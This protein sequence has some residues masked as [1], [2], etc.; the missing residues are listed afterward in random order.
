MIKF[1]LSCLS[2]RKIIPVLFSLAILLFLLPSIVQSSS[3]SFASA[4]SPGLTVLCYNLP[5]G[6]GV[7]GIYPATGGAFVEDFDRGNLVF[8]SGG[9]SKTIATA[10]PGGLYA[11][12]YYGMGAI[13][14]KAFGLVLALVTHN[15]AYSGISGLWLCYHANTSG[16]G[17]ESAFIPLP[18]SFCKSEK[19]HFCGPNGA[20]L[21]SSLNLFYVDG[22]NQQLVEC[23]S[24]SDYKSCI[25]LPASS[26]L[27]GSTPAGLFLSG[28]TFYVTDASC[29]GKVWTGTSSK[30]TLIAT[31]GEDI[32][33]IA[34]SANNPSGTLHVYLGVTGYCH[35]KAAYIL[36]LGDN[37][38]LPTP[39][40]FPND[41]PGLDSSL[42]FTG[43]FGAAYRTTDTS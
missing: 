11:F 21:D 34:L 16:C 9:H 43:V 35:N 29:S 13:N 40:G 8:C 18:S 39:F 27:K 17:S 1:R 22:A 15:G 32:E 41:V 12:G 14:T 28:K 10:P 30:L 33:S 24:S 3:E 36:D 6:N 37:K 4:S 31:L 26:A 23:T 38:P 42:Q 20:A 19:A 2:H 25:G 7:G 5:H